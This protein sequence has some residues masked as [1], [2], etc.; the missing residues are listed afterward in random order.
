MLLL[1]GCGCE[2]SNDHENG[3]DRNDQGRGVP[4]PPSV[5]ERL[6]EHD[7]ERGKIEQL[8]PEFRRNLQA[9][10]DELRE[11][12]WAARVAIGPRTVEEQIR[13][14]KAR[15]TTLLR[16]SHL[17]DRA[18]DLSLYPIGIPST[19]HRFWDVKDEVAVGLGLDVVD[20]EPG[21]F[22]DRPHVQSTRCDIADW[23]RLGLSPVGTFAGELGGETLALTFGRT[24]E[25]TLSVAARLDDGAVEVQHFR[26]DRGEGEAKVRR[27]RISLQLG[28]RPA[29][30]EF[31]TIENDGGVVRPDYRNLRVTV[32]EDETTL[33]RVD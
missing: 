6:E 32:G 5:V 20:Y 17:C 8:E 15:R 28:G 31:S 2:R 16:G 19:D 10:L 23:D 4:V 3:W 13:L 9:L 21:K 27:D 24:E 18:A 14:F 33:K 12:G 7:E 22:V 1:L 11:R 26:R 29:R 30:G 25:G